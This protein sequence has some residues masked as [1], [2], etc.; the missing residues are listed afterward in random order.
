MRRLPSSRSQFVPLTDELWSVPSQW[1]LRSRAYWPPSSSRYPLTRY[2]WV[3]QRKI[4]N[5]N[6]FTIFS[7]ENLFGI[8][9]IYFSRARNQNGTPSENVYRRHRLLVGWERQS[10]DSHD[11]RPFPK[12]SLHLFVCFHIK[13]SFL[14]LSRYE[15]Y[16]SCR[17][18]CVSI[19]FQIRRLFSDT[20]ILL[21]LLFH[22]SPLSL[23][24]KLSCPFISNVPSSYAYQFPLSPKANS[25]RR[26]MSPT[27]LPPFH[28]HMFSHFSSLSSHLLVE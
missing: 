14:F 26:R 24:I 25:G 15:P 5:S 6:R 12:R 19:S 27:E 17:F 1:H 11:S 28:W 4:T 13:S 20:F 21:V 22:F 23:F 2:A 18:Y 10:H 3:R 16:I 8:C 9:V 7:S